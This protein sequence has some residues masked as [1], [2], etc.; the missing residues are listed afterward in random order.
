[1]KILFLDCDGTIREPLEPGRKFISAP[2]DQRIIH[3][4]DRAI[5]Y[6][7]SKNWKIFGITNQAGVAAGHKSL[8]EAILTKGKSTQNPCCVGVGDKVLLRFTK[9]SGKLS[10]EFW[11]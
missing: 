10:L 5:A 3:G 1:M 6:Y 11:A 8:K 7:A 2:A 4:A 9:R